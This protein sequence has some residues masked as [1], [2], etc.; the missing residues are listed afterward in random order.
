MRRELPLPS[1]QATSPSEWELLRRARRLCNGIRMSTT[2]DHFIGAE[3]RT[4]EA[5]SHLKEQLDRFR[6][7]LKGFRAKHF[8]REYLKHPTSK[9]VSEWHQHPSCGATTEQLLAGRT[10]KSNDIV[11]MPR[12]LR[13]SVPCTDDVRRRVFCPVGM[14]GLLL[15]IHV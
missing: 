6:M 2:F 10:S 5:K 13:S 8:I 9:L 7:L 4:A 15:S 12:R 11:Q 3:V 1:A 14:R